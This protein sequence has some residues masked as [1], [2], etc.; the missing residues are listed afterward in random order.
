MFRRIRH[1]PLALLLI[2][3]AAV[4]PACDSGYTKS[5]QDSLT[6]GERTTLRAAQTLLI[7]KRT[8][9]EAH[10]VFWSDP[11]QARAAVC[12]KPTRAEILACLEPFTPENNDKIVAAL[13][14]YEAAAT[15][16]GTTIIAMEGQSTKDSILSV[17]Q[18][19][20]RLVGLFPKAETA[21]AALNAVLGAI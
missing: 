17:T 11:L 1:L 16:A 20:V 18:A 6:A 7:V 8:V 13:E 21:A 9:T 10:K 5:P 2:G 3:T 15:L 4:T 12:N 14:A 19:A